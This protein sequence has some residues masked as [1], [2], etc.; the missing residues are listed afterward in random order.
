MKITYAN[1]E[2]NPRLLARRNAFYFLKFLSALILFC[3]AQMSWAVAFTED[4]SADPTGGGNVTS[5]TTSNGGDAFTYTFTLDGEAGDMNWDGPNQDITLQSSSLG[6]GVER[7]SI[8][9]AANAT[10]VFNSIVIDNTAD[11]VTV[12]GYLSGVGRGS[13]QVVNTGVQTLN[14]GGITVDEVRITSSDF[15]LTKFD[16]FSGDTTVPNTSPV[17]SAFSAGNGP[18]EALTYTFATADFSYSDA[19]GD[20]Q[21]H[22]LIEALPGAGT[23]YLDA[24]ANDLYNVGEE[25]SVLQQISLAN[26][27]AGN[28]QYIQNGSVNTSFQF[29]VDDGTDT[30]T[31]NYIA[32][33]NMIAAPTVTLGLAPTSR[34]EANTTAN[35]VTATLSN[36]FAANTTVSLGYTGTATNGVDYS[37]SAASITVTAGATSGSI[38][39][40]NIDDAVQEGNETIVIDI[41]GVSNGVESGTQQVTFTI[42]D[43]DSPPSGYSV[44]IDQASISSAN[45]SSFS[46]TFAGA[47]LGATY[48]YSVSS[49]GGGSNVTG[50]GTISS[51]SVQITGID[52]SGLGDGTLALSV[53]LTNGVGT[54]SAATDTVTKD[55]TAPSGH[56]VSFDQPSVT[57][58]NET[59]IGFTFASAEVG[60]DY[61]YTVSS[62]G[63]GTNVTGSGSLAS[64]TD[65]ITPLNLSGL[66]DGTL[67]LSVQLTDSF[68]NTA[69]AVTDTVDKDTLAPT[70]YSVSFDQAAINNSN[71]SAASFTFAGA[72]VGADYAYTISSSGGRANVTGSGT[73]VTA[74]DQ[75]A[76][77]DLGGLGDGTLTLSVTLTDDSNNAGAA[78]TDTTQKDE[79]APSGYGT[80]IDLLGESQINTVNE[81]I[82]EF[83]GSG[84]E[85]GA[86]LN[87]AFTSNGGGT[88]VSGT[89]TVTA[90]TET[91]DNG[92][93]GF[94]LSGLTD[95]VVTLTVSLEDAAGNMG[96]DVTDTAT[97][98]A[99]PPVGYSV[100]WDQPLIGG[101]LAAAAPF[102][103]SNA[104]VGA[105]INY[106]ITSSGDGNTA[107]VTGS[108]S[109]ASAT[110]AVS[111]DVSSL[112]DGV[113]TVS[114]SLTDAGSN[115]GVIAS[116][117]SATLETLA[118][119]GYSVTIDQAVLDATNI[120]AVSF[121]F[122][123]AEVGA[124]YSYSFSSSGGG[125]SVTGSGV[126]ATATDQVSGIDL[127]AL[128]P[129]TITLSVTLEDDAGNMGASVT[130]SRVLAGSASAAV[131]SLPMVGFEAYVL[132]LLVM[133]ATGFVGL[134][135]K[136]R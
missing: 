109:A 80:A 3:L 12:Q 90:A 89:A 103:V 6:A 73:I 46:F 9:R 4:F 5:F 38:N 74:T 121:T 15:F 54:G 13:A 108:A 17:A 30:S 84:L 65:R 112:V 111:A 10:F 52:V 131:A 76:S 64:A 18:Y 59:A 47:E 134:R 44:V 68:G 71:V 33:L 120:N 61:S 45:Q 23:L 95:G 78:A 124:T 106:T 1:R 127:G 133:L 24:N 8:T 29:E 16:D 60:A 31:G 136:P 132:M 63:G 70:G 98:D 88:P 105:S 123:G 122:A 56:S 115:T 101:T 66:G 26:L 125:S 14:F 7:I 72:E 75:I 114:L 21:D 67:T 104:E 22:L 92:G 37:S 97:K 82:I 2:A 119:Q 55:A 129:G 107:T 36:S 116:D 79:L 28:L 117:N 25:V 50:T 48:N 58:A 130:G 43:D 62:D 135:A 40:A 91:F 87:Y 128:P 32:T 110:Q 34:A 53:T 69:P 94:D 39:I 96:S 81:S 19:N 51:A 83:S 118:P 41:T 35:V 99:G 100:A 42:L 85:V 57:S 86:T 49:S 93:A 126:I 27:N 11:P 102:T 77:L 113:L 20:T